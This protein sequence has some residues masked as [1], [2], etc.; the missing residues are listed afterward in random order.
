MEPEGSL[1]C[2]QKPASVHILRHMRP[3]HTYQNINHSDAELENLTS[4]FRKDDS[5][6]EH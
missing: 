5:I 2:W 1:P 3:V 6:Y 4:A